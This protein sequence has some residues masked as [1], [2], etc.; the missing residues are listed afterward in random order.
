[1]KVKNLVVCCPC[2]ENRVVAGLM[3]L[4]ASVVRESHMYSRGT[5]EVKC[6][7]IQSVEPVRNHL[8]HTG[9]RGGTVREE[10]TRKAF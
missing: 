3:L 10:P 4:S 7:T 9:N 8:F 2:P 1:M 6:G 5:G